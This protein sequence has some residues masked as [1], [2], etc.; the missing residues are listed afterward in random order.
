[1]GGGGAEPLGGSAN[2]RCG[3]FL[4]KTYAKTKELD[5]VGGGACWW[6]PPGSATECFKNEIA[7]KLYFQKKKKKK[8]N[9]QSNE[10]Y[11]IDTLGI[12]QL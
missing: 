6:H 12:G 10:K 1:M 9:T 4:A 5:P 8:K 3:C 11:N 7:R 2:L